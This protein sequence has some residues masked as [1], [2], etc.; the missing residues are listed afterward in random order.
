HVRLARF[1]ELDVGL[2]TTLDLHDRF[3]SLIT[4]GR[5]ALLDVDL[6]L[7]LAR[8]LVESHD[9]LALL[10]LNRGLVGRLLLLKL[11]VDLSLTLF[12]V[13]LRLCLTYLHLRFGLRDPNLRVGHAYDDLRLRLV[14]RDR[15]L[16]HLDAHGRRNLTDADLRLSLLHIDLRRRLGHRDLRGR[17]L[18]GHLGIG[19]AHDDAAL[20]HFCRVALLDRRAGLD[21]PRVANG[22]VTLRGDFFGL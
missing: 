7:L 13:H 10:H 8:L 5:L 21:Q 12:D 22:G 18:Y 2:A 1:G 9:R 17:L 15:G 20:D 6:R 16:R 3:G 11:H 19:L 14:D 4:D